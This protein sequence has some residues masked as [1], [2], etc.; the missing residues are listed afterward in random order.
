MH[1]F[2]I[3]LSVLGKLKMADERRIVKTSPKP[4]EKEQGR[5][6][7]SCADRVIAHRLTQ[8]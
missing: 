8:S 1:S 7:S 4:G 2:Y 6:L 5:V 3:T